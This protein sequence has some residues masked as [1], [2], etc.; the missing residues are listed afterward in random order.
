MRTFV[1]DA[2]VAIKW[3]V[4]EDDSAQALALRKNSRLIAPDLL[5]AEC[6]NILWKKV[7]RGEIE[8]QGARLANELLGRSDI[9]LEPM[10]GLSAEALRL[11]VQARTRFA[12]LLLRVR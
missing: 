11:A 7:Q 3:V 1:V 5:V 12:G 9:G 10:S 6:A 4:A 2:S 8:S